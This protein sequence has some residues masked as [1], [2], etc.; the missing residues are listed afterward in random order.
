[1]DDQLLLRPAVE[2]ARRLRDRELSSR[3][4]TGAL[5][6]PPLLRLSQLLQ[7]GISR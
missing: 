2:V 3:E 5:L 1:M 7:P 4:L 6:A